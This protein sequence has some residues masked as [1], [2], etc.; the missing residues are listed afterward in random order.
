MIL[1]DGDAVPI[2]NVVSLEQ[3]VHAPGKTW[4]LVGALA[5]L[6]LGGDCEDDPSCDLGYGGFCC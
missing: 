5:L 3:R 4:G 6:L 1:G 2:G